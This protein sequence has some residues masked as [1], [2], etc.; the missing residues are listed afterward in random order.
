MTVTDIKLYDH[1]FEGDQY[2]IETTNFI[3]HDPNEYI[4]FQN[5]QIE[6][7]QYDQATPLI[8]VS[9]HM[10]DHQHFIN[11]SIVNTENGYF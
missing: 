1:Q 9:A 8:K 2:L 6:N 11:L 5:I 4:V 3:S 7:V 10:V